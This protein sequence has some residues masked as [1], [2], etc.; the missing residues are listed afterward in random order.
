MMGFRAHDLVWIQ[1]DRLQSDSANTTLPDWVVSGSGPVV[2]RRATAAPG[3]V[4]VGVRGR[5]KTERQAAFAP[6]KWIEQYLDPY[7]LMAA[8]LWKKHP[9]KETHP[10]LITLAQ[11]APVLDQQGLRWGVTGSMGY[12]LATGE[13]Q[14]TAE[15]D[16][17]LIID[18]P[19]SMPRKYAS[20][21][22]KYLDSVQCRI[23]IQLETPQGAIALA[24]WASSSRE[25]LQKTLSGPRLTA[26]PW[27][28]QDRG[29][30]PC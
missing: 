2:V 21:L 28:P 10:V 11:V 1:R 7:T 26:T 9:D 6:I 14:L 29:A 24:E 20:Q 15:S 23:D 12:E 30:L 13:P 4:P 27:S 3:R 22:L 16:L 5:N 8:Q 25:V 18:M 17:D 19:H